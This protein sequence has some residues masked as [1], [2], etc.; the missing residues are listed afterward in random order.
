M[1]E[2]ICSKCHPE[3]LC[4]HEIIK[5]TCSKCHPELLCNHELLE[6]K[7]KK[8]SDEPIKIVIERFLTNS[9]QSDKKRNHFDIANFIDPHFCKLLID[10][11]EDKCCYCDCDLQYID[12]AP[13]LITIERIDNN[14]GH[15]KN[16]VKIACFNCNSTR[17]GSK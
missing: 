9:K 15:V 7:C 2:R 3:L 10:E 17:V 11:S 14:R 8:C 4:K 16:N 13:N 12:F 1:T 6:R 5:K